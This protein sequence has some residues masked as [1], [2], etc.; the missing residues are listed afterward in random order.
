MLVLGAL[1]VADVAG[2]SCFA[3]QHPT[4]LDGRAWAILLFVQIT[5]RT[6]ASLRLMTRAT[7]SQPHVRG[8]TEPTPLRL[9]VWSDD[10]RGKTATS[11]AWN[12]PPAA[13][14]VTYSSHSLPGNIY[15]YVLEVLLGRLCVCMD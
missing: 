3:R 8:M 14:G 12:S 10:A 9:V 13:C 5:H 4:V 1:D 6:H 2:F 15:I 11:F 7:R